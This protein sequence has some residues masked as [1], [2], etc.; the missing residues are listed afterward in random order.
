MSKTEDLIRTYEARLAEIEA[1]LAPHGNR[2][3]RAPPRAP[4]AAPAPAGGLRLG[5]DVGGTFTDLLLLDAEE[6][7]D[8]VGQGPL[9]PAGHRPSAC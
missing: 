2:R 4:R 5:V 8:L 3:R 9:D 7:Q 1:R 6:R